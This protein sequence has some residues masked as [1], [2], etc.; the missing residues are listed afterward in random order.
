MSSPLSSI[1][2]GLRRAAIVALIGVAVGLMVHVGSGAP[3]RPAN[4]QSI[5]L[6]HN[7]LFGVLCATVLDVTVRLIRYAMEALVP[8]RS[9]RAVAAHALVP[10]VGALAGA[11]GL[12]AVLKAEFSTTVTASWSL[13]T[14]LGG[15]AFCVVAGGV[16]ALTLRNYYEQE[17]RDQA[18]GWAARLRRLRPQ[19]CPPVLFDTLDALAER[20]PDDVGDDGATALIDRLRRLLRYRHHAT[21]EEPVPL[22]DEIEAALA[23]IELAQVH[24][25]NLEV[26]FD[27]PDALLRVPVPRLCLLPLLEN[28]VQHGAAATDAPCTITV[29]G[30][31]DDAQLCLAVLDTGPGFDTTDPDTVLRRGSGLADLYARLRSHFDAGADLSLLPQGVLWC[32]SVTPASPPQSPAPSPGAETS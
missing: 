9:L 1:V 6:S 25:P 2:E 7:L 4:W 15:I 10:A 8:P 3:L 5:P 23:Y 31:Y 21:A 16:G 18:E 29:T 28:A 32:A 30:R 27:V 19:T 12:A 22:A 26:G 17:R 11:G 20:L 24:H 14:G 13:L